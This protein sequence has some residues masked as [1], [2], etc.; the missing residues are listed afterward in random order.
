M[1]GDD[2][3]PPSLTL[4]VY[5]FAL[6]AGLAFAHEGMIRSHWGRFSLVLALLGP[7]A[8]GTGVGLFFVLVLAGLAFAGLMSRHPV[9]VAFGGF[10]AFLWPLFGVVTYSVGV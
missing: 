1:P 3:V 4:A 5:A 6:L 8:T 9:L 10:A 7:A 2:R